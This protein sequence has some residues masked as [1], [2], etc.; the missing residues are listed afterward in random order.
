MNEQDRSVELRQAVNEAIESLNPLKVVCG[1]SKN[2][3]GRDA[4]G[5]A[6]NLKQHQGIVH[7]HPSELVLT[8]RAGT[9]LQEIDRVLAEHG[10]M[11][12]F[13]PPHFT[14]SASLGGAVACG[15]SGPRRPFSG[16]VRDFVLGCKMIN[17]KGEILS[18]GG[19]VMKN[20][21][22]F[23]VSRLMTGA[24]GT[25]GVLLEISLKVMPLPAQDATLCFE[26]P[27]EAALNKMIELARQSLPLSGLSYDGAVLWVR[28]SGV[29]RAVKAASIKL[30]GEIGESGFWRDLNEQRLPF[31]QSP[32]PLWRISV[33]P[34]AAPLALAG[35]WLYDWGGGQRWLCSDEPAMKVFASAEQAEGHALL[36]RGGDRSGDIFQ[37]ES[38]PLLQINR[39]LKQAFDPSGIFNPGRKYK[40]W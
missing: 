33:P 19:E 17:G 18:F 11:L 34:A 3:Y 27:L 16:S 5:Q 13:E 37:P 31:F 40:A 26:L 38:L 29:E 30:G 14:D 35:T 21:A 6:L 39:N 4:Q 32:L 10:Q 7:Y 2:F 22:G 8:A 28:L 20:V 12:A 23:D 1:D 15:L 36:F 9:L 25:L 24:L